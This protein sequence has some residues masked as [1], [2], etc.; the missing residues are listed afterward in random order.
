MSNFVTLTNQ[1]MEAISSE[2]LKGVLFEGVVDGKDTEL[3]PMYSP[4]GTRILF[5]Q[6]PNGRKVS[7]DE[8]SPIRNGQVLPPPPKATKTAERVPVPPTAVAA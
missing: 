8:V 1:H 2:H 3:S 5:Y 4:Q 7:P 6:L